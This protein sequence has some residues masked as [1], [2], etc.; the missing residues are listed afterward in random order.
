M[1]AK[2]IIFFL[3]QIFFVLSC[4]GDFKNFLKSKAKSVQIKCSAN[5]FQTEIAEPN[6]IK[7]IINFIS[8]ENSPFYKCGYTG[9]IDF[10]KNNASILDGTISFNL[11][12]GCMH[13][14]YIY[15]EKIFAKKIT[16]EGIHYLN[17]IC[18]NTDEK[19]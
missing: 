12:Q 6:D 8:D 5:N 13:I 3:F 2:V 15:N 1:R 19:K 10:M 17:S 16:P 11:H 9:T 4:G 14:V 18:K 7:N